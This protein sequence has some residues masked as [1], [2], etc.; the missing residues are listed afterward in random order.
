MYKYDFM[1]F[2]SLWLLHIC[3]HLPFLALIHKGKQ[4]HKLFFF[5]L[6]LFYNINL[7]TFKF[8]PL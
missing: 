2:L 1:G 3:S 8:I 4:F 6:F 5:C 7:V